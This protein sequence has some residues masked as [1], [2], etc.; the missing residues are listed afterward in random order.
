MGQDD[1]VNGYDG[2]VQTSLVRADWLVPHL[3]VMSTMPGVRE[4]KIVLAHLGRS[5]WG[6]LLVTNAVVF[7]VTSQ[8]LPESQ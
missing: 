3:C 7:P 8:Y 5:V 4:T 1:I 2:M 6:A